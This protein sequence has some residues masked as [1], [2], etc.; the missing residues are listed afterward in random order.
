MAE[1]KDIARL[2]DLNI[3]MKVQSVVEGYSGTNARRPSGKF[4]AAM[5]DD[6]PNLW[7]SVTSTCMLILRYFLHKTYKRMNTVLIEYAK[8]DWDVVLEPTGNELPLMGPTGCIAAPHLRPFCTLHTCQI[9][10]AGTSGNQEWDQKYFD[11]RERI[12][13][14]MW[15]LRD[16][17][18]KSDS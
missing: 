17:L 4:A 14:F 9:N 18:G 5:A 10:G 16:E 2:S 3:K 7:K 13:E 12:D 8:T 1:S 11:L 15:E 6:S